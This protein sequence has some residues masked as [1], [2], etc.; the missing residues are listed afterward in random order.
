MWERTR[1]L[2]NNLFLSITDPGLL[3]LPHWNHLHTKIYL[4]R[5]QE[6]TII[7]LKATPKLICRS[8]LQ[9]SANY[10]S[11]LHLSISRPHFF[12]FYAPT[13]LHQDVLTTFPSSGNLHM[14]LL[15]S[16]VWLR[17]L[18]SRPPWTTNFYLQIFSFW[19]QVH[20]SY[21]LTV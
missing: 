21:F 6:T 4:N 8:S 12:F 3:A 9:P 18:L 13:R 14:S 1:P 20:N 19:K 15:C 5:K 10:Y 7:Q 16:E 11:N 2:L 17:R